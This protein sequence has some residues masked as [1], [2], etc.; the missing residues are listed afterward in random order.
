MDLAV[1]TVP[2]PAV[3]PALEGVRG[4]GRARRR[5]DLGGLPRS[6]RGGARCARRSCASGCATG[7]SA[8]SAPT[9]SGWIRPSRRL[10]LTFAPG[11]A[12]G[13][14]HRLRLALGRARR[15][16]PR[17]G[18]RAAHGLL[19]LREPRQPGR[20][21]RGGRASTRW[22]ATPRRGSS[23]ATSRAWR[24]GG[25]SSRRC[26]AAAAVK[27]VVLLKA[28]RSAE[29]ARAVSS[30]TGALAGSDQAFDAAVK[31]AGARARG[32]GRGAVRPRA[33]PREPAPAARP[34]PC[35]RDQWRRARHRRHRRG[36]GRR[37]S[38]S[39]PLDADGARAGSPPCCRRR[40]ASPIPVDLVGDADAARYGNALTRHRRRRRR[41]RA[42]DAHGPGGDGR[43]RGGARG[44]RGHAWLGQSRSSPP[45]SAARASR[46]A[47]GRSRRRG[48]R[49][50]LSRSRR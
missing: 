26:C 35:R 3:L 20:H 6:R 10:N 9:A 17:L 34:P 42:R 12:R 15:R 14:G 27:P 47:C 40:P 33:R 21:H 4:Q 25:A 29:G 13:R 44:D 48:S 16:H 50:I 2:A 32:H 24:T 41:C 45:S 28:G 31:Q 39:A 36:A 11:H 49:V 18:A 19:A 23:S 30:H 1:V 8:S 43:A 7:R 5:G 38:R 22:P 46:R 37:D